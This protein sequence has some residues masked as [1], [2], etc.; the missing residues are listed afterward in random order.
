MEKGKPD[1]DDCT[2]QMIEIGGEKIYIIVGDTFVQATVPRENSPEMSTT[3][4]IVEAICGGITAV[5]EI[6][7]DRRFGVK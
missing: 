7:S 2:R 6:R 4:D 1:V 3:R 5:M